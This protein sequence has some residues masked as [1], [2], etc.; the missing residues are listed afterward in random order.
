MVGELTRLFLQGEGDVVDY[1][2]A[3]EQP[4]EDDEVEADLLDQ[5]GNSRAY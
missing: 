4:L 3:T 2:D 1:D 5:M